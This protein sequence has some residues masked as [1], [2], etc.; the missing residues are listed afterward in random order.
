MR[1]WKVSQFSMLSH[2][3]GLSLLAN[4]RTSNARSHRSAVPDPQAAKAQTRST[5]RT[6]RLCIGDPGG[7]EGDMHVLYVR[8]YR[9]K[10][11]S[12]E[13]NHIDS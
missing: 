5:H 6:I 3:V 12:D 13:W 9:A 2:G 8:T 1:P 10:T 7:W 11:Q 4:R